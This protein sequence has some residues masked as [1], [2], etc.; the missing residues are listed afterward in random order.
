[1][2]A[3]AFQR[4]QAGQLPQA[5][6]GYRQVLAIVPEH[7]DALHLLGVIAHQ[8]GRDP[9]AVRLIR[10]A[11]GINGAAAG[12]HLN[13]GDALKAMGQPG[14]AVAAYRAALRIE[15][16]IA[17]AH[18]K[19]GFALKDLGQV[20]EAI[21]A[22]REAVR[23]RPDFAEA[24]FNLGQALHDLGRQED[25]V[26]AFRAALRFAP[27]FAEV[28]CGLGLALKDL[29]RLG[30]A[31]AAYGAA[32]R[33]APDFA[34][35]H[36][37]LG[38]ALRD[39][40]RIDEAIAAFRAASRI[41][42]DFADAHA[43]LGLLLHDSGRIEEAVAA[44]RAVVRIRPESADAWFSLAHALQ[45]QGRG[46]EAE[47][48]Y[49]AVPRIKPDFAAAHSNLGLLLLESGRI[50]D[51]IEAIRTALR[52]T[53]DFAHAH[54]NLGL[55]SQESGRIDEAI[56][57]YRAALRIEPDA[58]DVHS[59]LIMTMHFSPEI[60][61]A[62]ILAEARTFAGR[63]ANAPPARA[64][65][66]PADPDRRLRVGYVSGDFR[67]HPAGIFLE[68][69]LAHH[70]P[71]AIEVFCYSNNHRADALTGRL[72]AAAGHW[73]NVAASPDQAVA[74]M[75]ARD[76]IDILIDLSGHT[77]LNRLPMFALRPAP[78]QATWLGFWGTTG[79]PA[80]DYILSDDIAIPLGQEALY[81]EQVIRLPAGRF[82]YSPPDYAPPPPPEP[83]ARRV[84]HVTFGSFNNLAKLSPD[85]IRL[86]AAVLHAV[87]GSHLLLKWKSLIDPGMRQRLT[88][89]FGAEGIA[90]GRLELRGVS[91]HEAM[92]GEYA[93]IDVALD[94]FPFSGG[95]TSC[96][97]L[98]MG[99]PLVTLP[100]PGAA[101]RQTEGFL[102]ALGLTA[103][104][105]ASPADY[106]RVAAALAAEAPESRARLRRRMADSPLCDGPG[107]A[108]G[109]E[110]AYRA[111]WRRW[112][113]RRH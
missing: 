55:A 1:M 90:A 105:A 32:L 64:F 92:L 7:A 11:I 67:S 42:P 44:L 82:C 113:A 24:R 94:P 52:I 39:A 37:N 72:R 43:S 93:D 75:V 48:A 50:G 79:L 68:R 14:D 13:L 51:A 91:P 62:A 33:I 80:I 31:I 99:V 47:A 108:R 103:W 20:E 59:N 22:Y 84:G 58:A 78:V 107:F 10:Q 106:V 63:C 101:S 5:E 71:A 9:L 53:P 95:L 89:A 21:A 54:A 61:E 49:R 45:A 86:W 3:E 112:C 73:R 96:E 81:S 27:N 109:L 83:P 12:Y 111:M 19:L 85:V 110:A 57:A 6:R 46:E 17:D 74:A 15:P 88:E 4:H 100:G 66:N 8:T 35:A 36:F 97:A 23:L 29:G 60:T 56:A 104:V 77:A 69:V 30:D 34:E 76:G 102:R 16:E 65:A 28:H 40:G 87:P 26:T 38:L 98:W 70:D 18:F 2:L 41:K 25:A